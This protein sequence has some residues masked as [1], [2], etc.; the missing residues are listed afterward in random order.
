MNWTGMVMESPDFLQDRGFIGAWRFRLS[1]EPG[2]N[3]AVRR[4]EQ[5]FEMVELR[6]AEIADFGIGE[7][8][9]QKIRL[10]HP[11]MPG[12]EE[13]APLPCV[14]IRTFHL[15]ARHNFSSCMG[16]FGPPGASMTVGS[17]L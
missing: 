6:F 3:V 2:K 12:A 15:R 5:K 17:T 4:L 13:K 7:M 1:R 8:A 11:A 10:A 14:Q 9:K 16:W